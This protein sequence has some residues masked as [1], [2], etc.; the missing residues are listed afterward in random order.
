[1]AD[2]DPV[3]I[4]NFPA[5]GQ[6]IFIAI[7]SMTREVSHGLRSPV[8]ETALVSRTGLFSLNHKDGLDLLRISHGSYLGLK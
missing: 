3:S 4:Y 1:M 5:F 7:L 8:L 2:T 6:G